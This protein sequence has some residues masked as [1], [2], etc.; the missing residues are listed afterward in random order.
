M[1]A[2]KVRTA[3]HN[4]RGCLVEPLKPRL[5]GPNRTE[6]HAP[7][8]VGMWHV[9]RPLKGTLY[10]GSADT[11]VIHEFDVGGGVGGSSLSNLVTN[12]VA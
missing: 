3:M 10:K 2:Q 4:F 12:S 9:G 11:R 7:Q 6:Q 8:D 1:L 5:L